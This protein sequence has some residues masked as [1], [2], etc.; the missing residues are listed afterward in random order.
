VIE[1]SFADIGV[2]SSLSVPCR[3]TRVTGGHALDAQRFEA[4]IV[5]RSVFDRLD[6]AHSTT[7]LESEPAASLVGAMRG[8][9]RA[10]PEPAPR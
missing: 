8:T 1:R 7:C 4:I 2:S 6:V 3:C 9:T 10:L 5:D